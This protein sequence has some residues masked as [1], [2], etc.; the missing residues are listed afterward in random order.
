MLTRIRSLRQRH[1]RGKAEATWQSRPSTGTLNKLLPRVI[2]NVGRLFCSPCTETAGRVRLRI[3]YYSSDRILLSTNF[4]SS[5]HQRWCMSRRWLHTAEDS[6]YLWLVIILMAGMC[7]FPAGAQVYNSGRCDPPQPLVLPTFFVFLDLTQYWMAAFFHCVS[8]GRWE[9]RV[10]TREWPLSLS[11]GANE[12]LF[13][14]YPHVFHL[15]FLCLKVTWQEQERGWT[16]RVTFRT[17][18]CC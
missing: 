12:P 11:A 1:L 9:P 17:R 18:D 2:I 16:L 13:L 6:P 5:L 3:K 10:L 7:A 14:S 15:L 4:P 8:A